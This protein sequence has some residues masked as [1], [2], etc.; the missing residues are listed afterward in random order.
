V[1]TCAVVAWAMAVCGGAAT[2]SE[3]ASQSLQPTPAVVVTPSPSS[4]ASPHI[5]PGQIAL[6]T[7][8]DP[9]VKARPPARLVIA[10]HAAMAAFAAAWLRSPSDREI[11]AD[12]PIGAPPHSAARAHI[13]PHLMPPAARPIVSSPSMARPTAH[14]RG[15]DRPEC[16]SRPYPSRLPEEREAARARELAATD[17]DRGYA[18]RIE[19]TLSVASWSDVQE[20]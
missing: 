18:A 12:D 7:L 5:D 16:S 10:G 20:H 11:G 9:A 8:A 17:Q 3:P 6:A 15:H 2:S 13:E 1:L 4:T 19:A 14:L